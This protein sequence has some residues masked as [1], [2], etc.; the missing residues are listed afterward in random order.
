MQVARWGN[1]LAVRLPAALVRKHGLKEGDPID[2]VEDD[3][4]IIRVVTRQYWLDE[5]ERLSRPLP[6]GW[7]DWKAVRDR[8]GMRA[9]ELSDEELAKL[10]ALEAGAE[11]AG[12]LPG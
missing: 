7:K 4:G 1:S 12:D 2:F 5:I 11:L 3:E 8:Y 6:D 10:R 9:L